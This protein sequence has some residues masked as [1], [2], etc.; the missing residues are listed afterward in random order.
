MF[1]ANKQV[2]ESSLTGEAEPVSKG[3]QDPWVM[4]NCAVVQGSGK[5]LVGAVGANSEWGRTL[6]TLQEAE[7]EETNLQKD[8]GAIVVA[9]SKAKKNTIRKR[10]KKTCFDVFCY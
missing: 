1:F 5:M 3:P 8:L 7:F 4:T 2:D 10:K 6:L 9:I